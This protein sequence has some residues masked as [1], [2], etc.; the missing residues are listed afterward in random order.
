[1]PIDFSRRDF[2]K[3]TSLLA[4]G[5]GVFAALPASIQKAMAINPASGSTFE[6]AEHIVLLMQENRSFDHCF[7]AL[8]GVRGFNDPRTLKL[9]NGNPVWAQTDKN[10]ATYLPFRLDMQQTK[11]TW[12]G[13]LPH[14]WKDQVDARNNGQY[15]QW[16]IAK[17]TGYPGFEGKPMTLGYYNREDIPFNYAFADAFTVC[18]QHFCSSLT[19]TTPNR[20][21]FWSGTL[22]KDGKAGSPALVRNSES[23]YSAESDWKTMPELLQENGLSWK[24]YQNE[25]SLPSGLEEEA[26]AWLSNFTDN[27]LEWFTRFRVRRS[28]K[29]EQYLVNRLEAYEKSLAELEQRTTEQPDDQKAKRALNGLRERKKRYI[30][31]LERCRKELA[32][33]LSADEQALHDHA[34]TTNE[35]DPAYHDTEEI[36]YDDHGTKR[37]M[38]VPKSDVLAN[39]RKDV[40]EGK[41]P[42]VSWL[43]APQYFSDHPSAPWFGAWYVSEVL[44]ILTH[45]EEVWK[46]TIF[47][48]TYDEN[49]GYF[50]HVPPFTAPDYRNPATGAVS[51]GI[52]NTDKEFVTM[53]DEI[54]LKGITKDN[55]REGPIGLGYRVP[56]VVASP[57]SRGGYV[58]SQVFDHTSV[59]QFIENFASRKTG[60]KLQLPHLSEWRRAIC[61]D[62]SSVF[63]PYKGEPVKQ[64]Q[65]LERNAYL[66]RIDEAR[67][68]P[69]PQGIRPLTPEELRAIRTNPGTTKNYFKQ[70]KGIKPSNALPYELYADASLDREQQSIRLVMK[71]ATTVFK[72][73]SMGSPFSVYARLPY[74]DSGN[75]RVI[76]R[77]WSFAVAAGE[78]LV[79]DIPLAGFESDTYHLEL[80]GP[81]GFYRELS[82]KASES[83][84]LV[85]CTYTFGRG[86]RYGQVQLLIRN[87]TSGPQYVRIRDNS[88]GQKELSRTIAP[89]AAVSL[90]LLL[91]KSFG[92]YD[93]SVL[94]K[95]GNHFGHRFAGRV[96]SGNDSYTDPLLS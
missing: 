92:W 63:R 16:L 78:Q 76:N 40:K 50:D 26:D 13:G 10:N 48:L 37:R 95:S 93:F 14:S 71:A 25:L 74:T 73:R 34:F 17:T 86:K 19:G 80:F 33:T 47:I 79:Y 28:R 84:P 64:P 91:E 41:M 1:M 55:A 15:D 66:Q 29:Y 89:H 45:N 6:D 88:Y 9:A 38:R 52:K 58:N 67:Y 96:E 35:F 72:E 54:R 31:E 77:N 59:V 11:I 32:E 43:V 12:M 3:K 62:L 70:E 4:G 44:D 2:L 30:A 5:A 21:Y 18:D 8:K 65:F 39:F 42:A 20:L 61:G 69:L 81:N 60:K 7:G 24:V 23:D 82:G 90:T 68:R 57:W 46:K 49:D 87:S 94:P 85:E 83:G 27:P 75:K 56:F 53:D 51:A 22:R 36:E